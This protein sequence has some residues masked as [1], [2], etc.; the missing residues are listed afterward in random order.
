MA[1]TRRWLAILGAFVFTM[2][3]TICAR[4]SP[5]TLSRYLQLREF[6]QS[7]GMT[8]TVEGARVYISRS[9]AGARHE[10]TLRQLH[11]TF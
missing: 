2:A 4:Q 6:Y 3:A 5:P 9:L 7:P 8:A 11:L 10:E 1:I